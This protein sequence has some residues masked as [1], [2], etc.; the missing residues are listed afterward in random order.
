[1]SGLITRIHVDQV[2]HFY[3]RSI[4]LFVY[5]TYAKL[6]FETSA[7]SMKTFFPTYFHLYRVGQQPHFLRMKLLIPDIVRLLTCL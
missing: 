3:M 1:M 6:S 2:Q 4:Y 5:Y 7:L